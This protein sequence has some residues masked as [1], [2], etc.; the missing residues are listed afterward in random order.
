MTTIVENH[1][2]SSPEAARAYDD[3]VASV[4]RDQQVPEYIR[5]ARR[6]ALLRWLDA[7]DSK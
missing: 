1:G 6:R 7:H 3:A 4:A 5:E 2:F